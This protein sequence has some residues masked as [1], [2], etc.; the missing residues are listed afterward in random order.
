MANS[1]PHTDIPPSPR[2]LLRPSLALSDAITG[3]MSFA[4]VSAASFSAITAPAYKPPSAA[5]SSSTT[6]APVVPRS[7]YNTRSSSRLAEKENVGVSESQPRGCNAANGRHALPESASRTLANGRVLREMRR[8]KETNSDDDDCDTAT[9][10][11]DAKDLASPLSSS[12]PSR[13]NPTDLRRNCLQTNV[14]RNL[15]DLNQNGYDFAAGADELGDVENIF[16]RISSGASAMNLDGGPRP[17][18]STIV[19][20]DSNNDDDDDESGTVFRFSAASDDRVN[21]ESSDNDS[22]LI[23]ATPERSRD[24]ENEAELLNESIGLDDSIRVTRHTVKRVCPITKLP[25]VNPV[26]NSGCG[27][28][29]EKSAVLAMYDARRSRG[30]FC[31]CPVAGCDQRV[32]PFKLKGL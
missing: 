13:A 24:N 8:S 14:E 7:R 28:V 11:S 6:N 16:R 12:T 1:Q 10:L 15:R 20:D 27:H 4:T 9:H 17:N 3:F 19:L 30:R 22:V 26:K 5:T 25:F 32:W 31:P 2:H 21:P 29:Y 18:N 23:V